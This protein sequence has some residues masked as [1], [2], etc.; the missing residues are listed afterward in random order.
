M[1][2]RAYSLMKE[3][4]DTVLSYQVRTGSP[5][6]NN[7]ILCP[8]CHVVHGR[9][10]DLCFPLTVLWAESGEDR[11][12]TE[13][14]ALI[15]WT[16]FNLKSTDGLWYN[17]A[18]NR[19]FATS[20]FAAMSIG[21]ALI[22]YESI[23]PD[24]IAKKWRGIFVRISDALMTV[25]SRPTFR[26]VVNYYCGIA[27]ELAMATELTGDKKY[28]EKSKYWLDIALERFDNE[29]LLYG[30]GYPMEASDGSHTVDM[31]Y[32]LEESLPLLL[33][34]ASLTGEYTELFRQRLKDHL[35]FLLPDGGIDNSFGTRHNKW[36]YWGSRTS[37][38]LI[39]GLSLTLDDPTLTDACER[40]LTLYEKC[41]H[42]G[43]I[44]MPMAHQAGEPSCLH[45]TFAHAK[46]LAALYRA[47]N[48]P[49][50]VERS[51]LP[52]ETPYGVK[53]FQ[54]GRLKLMSDGKFR[55]TVSA[56]RAMLLS[57]NAANGGGSLNLLYHKN[58]G[59]ICAATSYE[60]V[61]SE[62][63]NQQ[64]LRNSDV[65][66]C[67]TAQ[68]Y[69]GG[70]PACKDKNVTLTS[71]DASVTASAEKWQATYSLGDSFVID[72]TCED[73]VYALPLVCP[74][75]EKVTLS[76]DGLTLRLGDSLTVTSTTPMTC[77]PELRFFNQVGGLLYLPV[78][79][80]VKGSVRLTLSVK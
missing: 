8:A 73:E 3:W 29:G 50:A 42:N 18:S 62:P 36:T 69:I 32:N 51:T 68:F 77:D 39:S 19:W 16:E 14:D 70:Q 63:L 34:Y 35:E 43:L 66:P 44:S 71:T 25:D 59:V 21:E 20:A 57:D 33:R 67:M 13:A 40:V 45:H 6:T 2:K 53:D 11:Y 23:L 52:C 76:P 65:I 15:D 38:G 54:N 41:T 17:D 1:K 55:A 49:E 28:Y 26:P 9:I 74:K 60:Y 22:N 4:C 75:D 56:V 58:R 30:E 64:Y 31:G 12:L 24:A 7:S 72:L 61:P 80:E 46:A 10:A 37:D 79:V 47:D 5:Y 78:S 48:V 27:A